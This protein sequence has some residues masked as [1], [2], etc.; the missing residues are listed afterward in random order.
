MRTFLSLLFAC[1][2]CRGYAQDGDL[3]GYK[4]GYKALSRLCEQNLDQASRLLANDYSRGYF[5]SLTIQPGTDTVSDI[6]FL[7]ATPPDMQAQIAWAMKTTGG[8]WIPRSTPR[9]F[10]IPIFFCQNT[11]P[12]ESFFSQV[13]VTNN[14]GF[15]VDHFPDQWPEAAEGVWL[16]PLCP[17]VSSGAAR[18][19][20]P[21]GGATNAAPTAPT[22]AAAPPSGGAT[23]PPTTAA[24]TTAPSTQP[25]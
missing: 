19:A 17:M 22:T 25:N 5:V 23:T 20:P 4:G 16:H 8:Q 2:L 1:L 18:P 7:T 3:I 24:T 13:L 6:S 15:S 21:V 11:P 14:V 10:L 9:K 12:N